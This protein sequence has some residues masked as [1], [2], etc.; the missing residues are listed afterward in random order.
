MNDALIFEATVEDFDDKVLQASGEVPV[1]VDFWADWCGPCLSLAPILHK[2]MEEYVGSVRLAKV[3]ADDNMKLCGRYGLRGF[4]TV[5][6][7]VDGAEVGRFTGSKP[8]SFIRE[9]LDQHVPA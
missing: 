3:D 7:F 5:I 1:L 9:F 2:V 4:P 6:L 8:A